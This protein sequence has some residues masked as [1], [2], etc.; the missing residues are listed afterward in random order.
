MS[1]S[2][3]VT[4]TQKTVEPLALECQP[5]VEQLVTEDDKPVDNVFSEREQRLLTETLHSSWP[6]PGAGRTFLAFA[7][8]GMFYAVRQPP[9]VPDVL[10][11]LDVKAPGELSLKRNRSY[12]YWEYTKP[13]EVVIEIVS[14][15]EGGE[16]SDKLRDYAYAHVL[17]YVIHDPFRLLSNEVLRLY[18]WRP[19]GYVT[20][21]ETWLP[22]VGL[23]LKLWDGTYEGFEAT[24]L[25]WCDR[26]GNLI[27]TGAEYAAQQ[28]ARA[29]QE[30]LRA[31]A[32]EAKLRELG[33][34]P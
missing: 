2:D 23:G 19:T 7:N 32:L 34:E 10:L 29:E 33:V 27:L 11:S 18:E 25:R 16:D 21:N 5:D 22:Q 15:L 4:Q 1:V 6:G 17:Y 3:T 26:D 31:E 20:M 13:P 30:R 28:H 9:L 14:N 24:W 8:V 12:F